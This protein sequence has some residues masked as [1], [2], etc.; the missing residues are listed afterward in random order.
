VAPTAANSGALFSAQVLIWQSLSVSQVRAASMLMVVVLQHRLLQLVSDRL[1][2][3][4]YLA[5]IR[6]ESK[7]QHFDLA[8]KFIGGNTEE[9]D[10]VVFLLIMLKHVGPLIDDLQKRP[11]TRISFSHAGEI[12]NQLM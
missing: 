11:E 12:A 3:S 6:S 2:C 5:F 8:C 1:E 7:R 9:V 4:W 10:V